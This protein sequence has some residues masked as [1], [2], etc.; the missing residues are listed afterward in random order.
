MVKDKVTDK[1][2]AMKGCRKGEDW[3]ETTAWRERNSCALL[4]SPFTLAL[5]YAFETS[6]KLFTVLDYKWGKTFKWGWPHGKKM[7]CD[8]LKTKVWLAAM[9]LGVKEMKDKNVVHLD[10]HPDN[11]M[12][13]ELG[14]PVWVDFGCSQT[15]ITEP[16]KGG[17]YRIIGWPRG[18]VPELREK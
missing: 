10:G 14:Y 6:H 18:R 8:D 7:K 15:G 2:H 16:D 4:R 1:L 9:A 12:Y 17:N 11:M 13:D 5:H 3:R